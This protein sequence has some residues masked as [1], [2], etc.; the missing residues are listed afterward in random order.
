MV[1]AA[2]EVGDPW[3]FCRLRQCLE[4]IAVAVCGVSRWR[5][6]RP[7]SC[8][9]L[10]QKVLWDS[11]WFS[12]VRDGVV[13]G[14]RLAQ[15][16]LWVLFIY[17][18]FRNITS[19]CGVYCSVP[20]ALWLVSLHRRDSGGGRLAHSAPALR[21]TLEPG[22]RT[23]VDLCVVV[24]SAFE[25]YPVLRISDGPKKKK[26]EGKNEIIKMQKA[27]IQTCFLYTLAKKKSEGF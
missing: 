3:F 14:W 7:R 8:V 9:G 10:L 25:L 5:R 11:W 18:F 21:V 12:V 23:W 20:F 2:P 17:L 19:L 16:E 22:V 26:K 27:V 15:G 13:Q 1:G 6:S 24:V 4:W